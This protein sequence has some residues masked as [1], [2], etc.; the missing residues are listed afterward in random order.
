[1]YIYIYIIHIYIYIY[2]HIYKYMYDWQRWG[3]N[4]SEQ[5]AGTLFATHLNVYLCVYLC[6]H[7]CINIYTVYVYQYTD[8]IYISFFLIYI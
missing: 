4:Q 7:E 8:L 1:M 2:T 6:I 5:H 3:T